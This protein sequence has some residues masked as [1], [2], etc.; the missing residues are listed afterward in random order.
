[1]MKSGQLNLTGLVTQKIKPDELGTAYE[2]LLKKKDEY[3][4]VTV[5]WK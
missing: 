1:M 3:L 4:G 5:H 2:G